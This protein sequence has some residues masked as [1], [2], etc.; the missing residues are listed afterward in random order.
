MILFDVSCINNSVKGPLS[1]VLPS[2]LHPSTRVENTRMVLL[3]F[4]DHLSLGRP[5]SRLFGVELGT[6][7]VPL[8]LLSLFSST[9][10]RIDTSRTT[11]LLEKLCPLPL[12]HSRRTPLSTTGVLGHV[13]T[14]TLL[15]GRGVGGAEVRRRSDS[16]SRW[17]YKTS[18]F[19]T[20]V[21]L[22]IFGNRELVRSWLRC[23]GRLRR[24]YHG[25]PSF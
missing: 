25:P 24:Q 11:V 12:N 22:G 23:R 1:L 6:S 19:R 16:V 4:P 14:F 18:L 3:C 9:R 20:Q 2:D 5:T 21:L 10:G 7:V 8:G 13:L 17:T 15:W